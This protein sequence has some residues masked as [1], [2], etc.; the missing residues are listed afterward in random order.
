MTEYDPN[1]QP[2]DSHELRPLTGEDAHHLSSLVGTVLGEASSGQTY[3]D[4]NVVCEIA[5]GLQNLKFRWETPE[6]V[7][8][9]HR[10]RIQTS[11]STVDKQR[12]IEESGAR[13]RRDYWLLTLQGGSAMVTTSTEN[14]DHFRQIVGP[15]VRPAKYSDYEAA[16]SRLDVL[17]KLKQ[18]EETASRFGFLGKLA[19]RIGL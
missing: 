9:L 17:D 11:I 15:E 19:A 6:W 13:V 8:T 4:A 16:L 5:A 1:R 2:P 10:N 3:G 18:S 7:L 14:A 12:I